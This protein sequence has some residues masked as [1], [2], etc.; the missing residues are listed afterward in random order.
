MS[1]FNNKSI[2]ILKLSPPKC[3]DSIRYGI[4]HNKSIIDPDFLRIISEIH[5]DF[6][7]FSR[8]LIDHATMIQNTEPMHLAPRNILDSTPDGD[9]Q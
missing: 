7:H 9:T 1:N 4:I 3:P 6:A 2:L 8:E 5:Q